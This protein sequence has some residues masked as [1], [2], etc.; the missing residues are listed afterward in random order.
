MCNLHSEI[1]LATRRLGPDILDY[2][3]ELKAEG[4]TRIL[5]V[6][7]G[8]TAEHL[9][10]WWDIDYEAK[11]K[12]REL[13]MVLERTEL[14]NARPDFVRTVAAVLRDHAADR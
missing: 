6:P 11:E 5:Q 4:V 10:V 14:P 3:D 7:I 13:G 9:E 1:A 8:F 2:L 12:A